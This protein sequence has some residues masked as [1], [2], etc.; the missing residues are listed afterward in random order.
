MSEIQR[1]KPVRRGGSPALRMALIRN[2]HSYVGLFIAPSVLF[3]AITGGLQ[4]FKFHEAHGD[5][6]PAPLVE[7]LGMLHKDQKF[8]MRRKRPA[9][10]PAAAAAP[11]IAAASAT[12]PVRVEEDD[13]DHDHDKA[14]KDAAKTPVKADADA[15]APEAAKAVEG[16]AP[17]AD[18]PK[19]GGEEKEA[20][21][22]FK[23]VAI[24][25]LFLAV[26]VGLTL[27]TALG[28]WMA[29][30]PHRRN[31][32]TWAMLIAGTVLPVLLVV[33]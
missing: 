19:A 20:A 3:F 33:I 9:P 17:K 26:S 25:W 24:R 31:R 7:K 5:Y 16:G 27:S 10:T 13:D 8:E 18:A 1:D 22:P 12:G 11:S 2:I 6:T 28:V 14:G 21:E 23:L 32:L 30:Q 29:L 4:L 15:R